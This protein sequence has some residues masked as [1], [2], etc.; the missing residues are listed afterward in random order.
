[1]IPTPELG[2]LT[3]QD[4]RRVYEPAEDTFIL[5]DALEADQERLQQRQPRLCLEIGSGSGCVSAFLSK[6]V[7]ATQAAYLCID[8]NPEANR[9][10]R[11]T[12]DANGIHL[13]AVRTSLVSSLYPRLRNSVD[14]LL[15]NPP[16]VPT[17][18]EEEAMAQSQADL[19]GAWAGGATG[20]RLVDQLIDGGVVEEVLSPGGA[21]YL[22]AIRQNDPPALC[23]R[24]QERGLDAEVVL[25]RRAGGEHL[26]V[27]RATKAF[28][29]QR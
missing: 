2:H 1:M 29:H 3:S 6:V 21:F 14:V 27:V 9:C 24:L 11:L 25:A 7:G 23:K 26:H 5:L 18:E 8:I 28:V 16:Y 17:V 15:F 19:S 20:T 4:Y 12:G 10:T 22:V 13:E